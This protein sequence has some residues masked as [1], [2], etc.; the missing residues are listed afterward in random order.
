MTL[1]NYITLFRLCMLPVFLTCIFLY[2]PEAPGYKWAALVV[3]ALA[4]FSD[5]LD[6]Y[7]ARHY[8]QRSRFGAALDPAA[9]KLLVNLSLIFLAYNREFLTPIPYWFPVLSVARDAVIVI[10]FYLVDHFYGP[11]RVIPRTL[12]KLHTA[13]VIVVILVVLLEWPFAY[14]LI[15]FSAA[16]TAISLADYLWNG[17]ERIEHQETAS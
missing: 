12:G 8:N 7:I 11:M 2:R 15:L 4:G 16:L 1:A 13:V 17:Y 9:D 6:G 5:V 10:G 14:S 3:F